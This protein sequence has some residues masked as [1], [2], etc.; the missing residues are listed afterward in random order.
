MKL[1]CL[2]APVAAIFGLA[3][4]AVG[5]LY[6][7]DPLWN[8]APPSSFTWYLNGTSG[9][10]WN[11]PGNQPDPTIMKLTDA[12]GTLWFYVTG[13]DD[14]L[15][16]LNFNIYRSKDLHHWCLVGT[17]FHHNISGGALVLS[18]GRKLRGL[19]S[20]HLYVDPN[21]DGLGMNRNIYLSF[22]GTEV[23]AGPPN[24]DNSDNR[25][26]MVTT[27][28]KS[29]LLSG[30][31]FADPGHPGGSRANEPIWYYYR[32]NNSGTTIYTDG[33]RAQSVAEGITRTIPVTLNPWQEGTAPGNTYRIRSSG[34]VLTYGWGHASI[35][36]N[37]VMADAPYVYFE[38]LSRGGKRWMLYNWNQVSASNFDANNIAAYPM[39]DN[40]STEGGTSW[41]PKHAPI[42]Y[43]YNTSLQ[44]FFGSSLPNGGVDDNGNQWHNCFHPSC[45]PAGVAE[46]GSVFYNVA[47][48]RYYIFYN[49]NPVGRGYQLVYRV[50]QPGQ[51]LWDLRLKNSGGSTDWTD[52]STPEHVLV[53]GNWVLKSD[54][55]SRDAG[56]AEHFG[57]GEVTYAWG[58]PYVIF[59]GYDPASG[60]RKVYFKELTLDAGGVLYK[61]LFDGHP[62][63]DQ[64]LNYFWAPNSPGCS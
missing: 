35:G 61:R 8:T 52:Q 30:G 54:G 19:W 1:S 11:F 38:P 56:N 43:R 59:H 41:T 2:F 15:G 9:G 48:D 37:T 3:A 22:S 12:S 18:S 34:G 51:S 45:P 53:A 33:G 46:G 58:R 17:A 42:A 32:V 4:S 23:Y 16:T 39:Y 24:Y 60:Y 29:W 13:T 31:K 64:N 14:D 47:N 26:F 20:P 50:G 40:F 5:Q 44:P 6:W 36:T 63:L 21:E 27:M 57:G 28:S 7:Q 49:R 55:V 62:N 10:S 25:T